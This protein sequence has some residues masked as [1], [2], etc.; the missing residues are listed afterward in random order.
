MRV[1]F[2]QVRLA[3]MLEH[4]TME[5]QLRKLAKKINKAQAKK[6]RLDD[7]DQRLRDDVSARVAEIWA[8]VVKKEEDKMNEMLEKL[9]QDGKT[10]IDEI[11]G[12][13]RSRLAA[14]FGGLVS[15]L[16]GKLEEAQ[17]ALERSAHVFE[18]RAQEARKVQSQ[19]E[20]FASLEAKKEEDD[21]RGIEG[22]KIQA[23]SAQMEQ[24]R[25][26]RSTV[27]ELWERFNTPMEHR[28]AFLEAVI[29]EASEADETLLQ[30]MDDYRKKLARF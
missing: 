2:E 6:Q 20:E 1:H 19:L 5:A 22:S 13:V 14:E 26:S 15:E 21:K 8:P 29:N 18:E 17:D 23:T 7:R 12:V 25:Q 9:R 30:M 24:L 28:L 4:K 27:R 3:S 10:K 11:E 16:E